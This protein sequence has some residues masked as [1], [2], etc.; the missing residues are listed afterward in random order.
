[1]KAEPQKL[2]WRILLPI[3]LLLA[4]N[5]PATAALVSHWALN[6]NSGIT[7]IDSGPAGNTG[8]LT[9]QGTGSIVWTAGVS[10][11]ATALTGSTGGVNAGFITMGNAASLAFD[12]TNAFSVSAWMKTTTTQD[13]TIVGKMHQ[14]TASQPSY[15]GYELHFRSNKLLVW[16]INNYYNGSNYI[17]IQ[18]SV[19]LNDGNWHL[20]AFTYDG[21]G[22]ASG[23]TIYTD[24]VRD[25]ASV[26]QSDKLGTN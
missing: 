9:N 18:G 13:A 20:T 2:I 10:G 15:P 5:Q 4:E 21:S 16:L 12:T 11:S 22:L 26:I 7:A 14:E 25:P 19:T 1:M 3:A 6:E 24:G 23:V 17:Q 8:M